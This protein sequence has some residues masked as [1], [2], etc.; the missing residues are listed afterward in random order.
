MKVSSSRVDFFKD[1][2][3]VIDFNELD[4]VLSILKK[5]YATKTI[6]PAMNKVFEA[7]KYCSRKDLKI[8]MLSQDPY[9][10]Y[11]VAT[12][13][14]FANN[15][16]IV[17]PSLRILEQAAVNYTMPHNYVEFDCS[18]KPWE[19]Q[20]I[21]LLNSALT[22]ELNKPGSHLNLWRKFISNF[23]VS[24][25]REEIGIVYVLFGAYAQSFL[26][27][28]NSN[29]NTVLLEKHPAYYARK[30]IPMPN[31]FRDLDKIMKDMYNT[32]IEWYKEIK[33][34]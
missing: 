15:S 11:N 10:Q 30:G 6:M 13:I 33:Y 22:V 4:D 17:S 32:T 2:S 5:E 14:A 8:V 27:Y 28:I 18:L 21:L 31:I 24:L 25:S 29:F 16:K 23:L 1:W 19:S 34:V 9:P 20:G 26:P 7:F 12:G 3:K